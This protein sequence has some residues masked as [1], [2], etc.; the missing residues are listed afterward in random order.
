MRSRHLLALLA[1]LLSVPWQLWAAAA[2]P[3]IFQS[4]RKGDA[5]AVAVAL[6][7]NPALVRVK[8]RY[9]RTP[10][11]NAIFLRQEEIAKFLV[12]KGSPLTPF[13]AAALGE[14]AT[15][16]D[17]VAA[18]P[19]LLKLRYFG[20]TLLMWAALRHHPETVDM[21]VA[22]GAPLDVY[23]AAALGLTDKV[24]EFIA[25]DPRN[26]VGQDPSGITPLQ[27]AVIA[28]S[29]DSAKLLLENGAA[30]ESSSCENCWSPLFDAAARGDLP[31]IKLLLSHGARKTAFVPGF[32][33]PY[34]LALAKH[35]KQAA[36][37]LKP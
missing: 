6:K 22:Q 32:G 13:D 25:A 35:Q 3:D 17:M 27:V 36:E 15:L 19:S 28:G 16:R 5:T 29:V 7:R 20:R 10:L 2:G 11:T 4:I 33:T 24:K 8:D 37:L 23:A 9:G 26:I 21:L 30:P 34:T 12:A 1:L 14:T 18:N 31:M